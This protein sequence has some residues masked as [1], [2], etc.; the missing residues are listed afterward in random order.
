M[1]AS[2]SRKGDCYDNAPM[3]SF[4]GILVLRAK[5]MMSE[6]VDRGGV[7]EIVAGKWWTIGGG[8][9]YSDKKPPSGRLRKFNKASYN[10][11]HANSPAIEKAI[12]TA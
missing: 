7:L 4:W 8:L 11:F 2:I 1:I 10:M 5:I 6:L 3:E 9:K 12:I